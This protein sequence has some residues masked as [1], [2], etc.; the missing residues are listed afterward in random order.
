MLEAPRRYGKISMF[1]F[2][3]LFRLV[4]V[5]FCSAS[6]ALL[7]SGLKRAEKSIRIPLAAVQG[8]EEPRGDEGA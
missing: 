1:E 8:L 6:P 3:I 7:P 5:A 2:K 4:D